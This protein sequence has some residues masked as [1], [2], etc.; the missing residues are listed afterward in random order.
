MKRIIKSYPMP[1]WVLLALVVAASVAFAGWADERQ[2][3][4]ADEQSQS[5]EIDRYELN[6]DRL[7]RLTV[8]A[9]A[10]Q[11]ITMQGRQYE[12]GK[13]GNLSVEL[14]RSKQELRTAWGKQGALK[15]QLNEAR[16]RICLLEQ[17]ARD[18]GVNLRPSDG[19][20]SGIGQ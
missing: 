4:K 6:Y 1:L 17:L 16:E 5:E 13:N 20:K 15:A 12:A 9:M 2:E 11:A 10:A 18:N 7:A 3:R 8:S 14:E 19:C